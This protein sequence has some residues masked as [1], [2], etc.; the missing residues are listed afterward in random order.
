MTTRP[1]QL[2]LYHK[3]KVH[4]Q[5]HREQNINED[6]TTI[7]MKRWDV[8]EINRE[9]LAKIYIYRNKVIDFY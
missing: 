2:D 9:G 1:Y 3:V 8:N 4:E 5:I 6:I 7:F